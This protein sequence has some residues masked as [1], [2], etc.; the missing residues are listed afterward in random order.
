M[1]NKTTHYEVF[2]YW[3]DKS[4]DKYGNCYIGDNVDFHNTIPIVNDW[5]EPECY[6]C[7]HSAIDYSHMEDNERYNQALGE[8]DG[9]KYIY[10]RKDVKHN[11]QLA[12]IRPKAL[13]GEDIPSNFVLLC[14][15]CH[16]DA[17][18]ILNRKLF[19]SWIYGRRKEGTIY[20]RCREKAKIILHDA[21]G[22]NDFYA[23]T[24]MKNASTALD[25]T[26]VNT[27]GSILCED[28]ITYGF[29]QEA[30]LNR[31]KLKEEYEKMFKFTIEEQIRKIKSK[32]N[33]TTSTEQYSEVDKAILDTLKSVLTQYDTFKTLEMA[34]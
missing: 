28:T 3:K 4:I 18:D 34:E 7:G 26:K 11:L 1:A 31:T 16:R 23:L 13:Q 29:V 8:D 2:D 14:P 32:Y 15:R 19:L 12:H 21:Y 25:R 9:L 27:H 6:A 20:V 17:P 22:M 10:S 33:M 24:L 5:G 30:F